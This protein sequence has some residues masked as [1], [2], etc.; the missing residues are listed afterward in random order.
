MLTSIKDIVTTITFNDVTQ[1]QTVIEYGITP[2][3]VIFIPNHKLDE[4]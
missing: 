3:T 4:Q 1:T 2:T